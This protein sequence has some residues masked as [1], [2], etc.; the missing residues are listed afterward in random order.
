MLREVGY[1]KTVQRSVKSR[2]LVFIP[3]NLGGLSVF[4]VTVI[5]R[6]PTEHASMEELL[7]VIWIMEVLET[8]VA[9]DLEPFYRPSVL[10][11]GQ[12]SAF[13]SGQRSYRRQQQTFGM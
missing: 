3:Y 8:T 4:I 11:S 1:L 6:I 2:P 7:G 10:A 13:D 9:H 5:G 12:D